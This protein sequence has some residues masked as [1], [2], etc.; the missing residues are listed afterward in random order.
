[1]INLWVSRTL[2][3]FYA[4]LNNL[5]KEQMEYLDLMKWKVPKLYLKVVNG[6]ED[7]NWFMS[8]LLL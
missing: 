4:D 7:L 1:V 8:W 3:D 2:T 5:N 6:E